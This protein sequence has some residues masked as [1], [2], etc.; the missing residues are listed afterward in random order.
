MSGLRKS[1]WNQRHLFM[2]DQHV[3]GLIAFF[4][5]V[6]ENCKNKHNKETRA[7]FPPTNQK[8]VTDKTSVSIPHPFKTETAYFTLLLLVFT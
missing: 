3:N 5:E 4:S 2:F 6:I 1:T 8:A 7:F